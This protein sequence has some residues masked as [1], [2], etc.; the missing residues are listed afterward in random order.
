[1]QESASTLHS[2]TVEP[3]APHVLSVIHLLVRHPSFLTSARLNVLL[4]KVAELRTKSA[5]V[6]RLIGELIQAE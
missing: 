5:E 2:Q 6:Q 3:L 4:K 1:M